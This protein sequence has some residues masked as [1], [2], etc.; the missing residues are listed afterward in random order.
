MLRV[1][2]KFDV[3]ENF[4]PPDVTPT[5][6]SL[7]GSLAPRARAHESLPTMP[8]TAK[9]SVSRTSVGAAVSSA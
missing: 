5:A 7:L 9:R 3:D 1:W 8:I 2:E 6:M 4:S